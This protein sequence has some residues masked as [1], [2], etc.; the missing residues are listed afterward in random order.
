MK[1]L[2]LSAGKG[3]RL[4]PITSYFPK[5]LLPVG[6][7]R[8]ID[9][10]ISYLSKVCNEIVVVSGYMHEVLERYLSEH[11]RGVAVLRVEEVGSGN[12]R[13]LL[14]AREL[15]EGDEF[16]V[17]NADHIFTP[18]VWELFPEGRRGVQIACHR[19]EVREIFGDEMKVRVDGDL[20]LHMEKNL[21]NYEGA[22]TGLTYVGR[23]I[24]SAY[25]KTAES[26]FRDLGDRGRAEDVLNR[27]AEKRAVRVVWI[28]RVRFFEIDTISDL[29]EAWKHGKELANL[30]NMGLKYKDG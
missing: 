5:P 11:H 23:D 16:V 19:K 29:R 8:V 15:L 2:V 22:Y 21:E 14:R 12:L 30:Y 25:W 20:L 13:T 26:L 10:V 24:S 17:A 28:D 27:L 1:A 3:K 18:R 7:R 9:L 6:G 4:K